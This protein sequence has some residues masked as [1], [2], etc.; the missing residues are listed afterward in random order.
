VLNKKV[1]KSLQNLKAFFVSKEIL[2]SYFKVKKM[3]II[4]FSYAFFISF[5][6]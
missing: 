3:F 5:G 6:F 1:K 4:N 2:Y